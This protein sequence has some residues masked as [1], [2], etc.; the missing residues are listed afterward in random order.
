MKDNHC[1]LHLPD[2]L[3]LTRAGIHEAMKLPYAR[4]V[5]KRAFN[6]E[7][8]LFMKLVRG[9]NV[10]KVIRSKLT[11]YPQLNGHI[12][13]IKMIINDCKLYIY[14][15]YR[16]SY[17]R[18]VEKKPYDHLKKQINDRVLFYFITIRFLY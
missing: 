9:L 1:V 18:N 3:Q 2:L 10:H 17:L 14:M 11:T 4:L 6:W 16:S 12:N 13:M 8:L 5:F 7:K 15:S